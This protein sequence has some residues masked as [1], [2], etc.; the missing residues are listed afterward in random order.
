MC[1]SPHLLQIRRFGLCALQLCA[2]HLKLERHTRQ[3]LLRALEK[4]LRTFNVA[5]TRHNVVEARCN[6]EFCFP[7]KQPQQLALPFLMRCV[8][9]SSISASSLNIINSGATALPLHSRAPALL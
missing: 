1:Q 4:E 2:L 8:R 6:L 5:L 7:L 9:N 3:L